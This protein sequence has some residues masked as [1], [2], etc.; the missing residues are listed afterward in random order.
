MRIY[1]IG[2]NTIDLD[3]ITCVAT[4]R[5]LV[6]NKEENG[7]GPI[8]TWLVVIYLMCGGTI[9]IKSDIDSETEANDVRKRFVEDVW[10]GNNDE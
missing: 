8:E 10:K 9:V 5:T 7:P 6:P 4:R 3:K 2:S 1:N